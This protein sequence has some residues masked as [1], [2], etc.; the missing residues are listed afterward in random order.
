MCEECKCDDGYVMPELNI[1]FHRLTADH[2]KGHEG[3]A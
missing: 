2:L 1:I 3:K